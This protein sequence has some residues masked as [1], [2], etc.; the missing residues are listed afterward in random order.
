MPRR[1]LAVA[2]VWHMH[3]PWYRDDV[4]GQFVLP[5]VRRRA[6]KDYLHMLQVLD[7]HPDMR[8]TINMVPSL[9]A[10]LE[11]YDAGD[12]SDADRD[13]CL[14]SATDLTGAERAFLVAGAAHDD[15]GRRVGL[16]SPYIELVERLS[17]GDAAS[18]DVDD[19]RD[20]QLWSLL[21]W[22]D[23]DQIRADPALLALARRGRGFA[24]SDKHAVDHAQM[25]LLRAVIPAYREAVA[26]G[27]VEPM[28]SPFHHPILPL[29]IGATSA[30]VATPDIALPEPPLH[31]EPDAREHVRRGLDSFERVVGRHAAAMW[32]PECAVSP[33]AAALMR[34]CGVRFAIS[35]ELVLNRTLGHAARDTGELYR[36]HAD[37]SGLTMVFRDAVLS[38]LIGFSYQSMSADDAAADLLARLTGIANSQPEDGPERLVTIALDGE[39]FKDFYAENAT[40]F[41]DALYAGLVASAELQTTHIGAFLDGDSG[42]PATLPQLWT[43]SWVNADLR[44][45]IGDQ[46]HTR[47]WTLLAT[48]RDTLLRVD[49]P[50]VHPRAWDEL[51]I[52]ESSDWFWWFGEHHDSGFDA[53]WDELFRTHL[54]NAHTLAGVA[55]PAAVD[56]PLIASAALAHDCAPLRSIDPVRRG[57]V[58]W[59]CA[60]I[61]D[62]GAVYGAMRPPASSV[63]RI[64]YGA[65]GARLHIRFGE[66]TPRFDRVVIDAGPAGTLVVE[67]AAR[68]LSVATPVAGPL[69]FSITLE[70]AGRGTERVPLH[71]ALHVTNPVVDTDSRLRVVIVAAE[72]APL[73]TAGDLAGVVAAT[74]A[75]AAELGYEVIVITPHHREGSFGRSPGVRVALLTASAWGAPLEARVVQGALAGR[76]VPVLSIDAPVW[77]DRDAVYGAIDDGE[78]YLAFCALAY[79][80]IN[81]TGFAPDLVHGFEWQTAALLARVAALPSPPATI[82]S[83]G[84]GS[85]GYVVDAP[86]LASAGLAEAGG[87]AIDLIDLGRRVATVV[88]QRPRRQTLAQTYDAALSLHRSD[89]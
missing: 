49:A 10:Q 24:E 35:D 15:Y 21:A 63:T 76:E 67:R 59:Q 71:G 34:S 86:T 74:A 31:A 79:T 51:L 69:D 46:A 82:L 42:P 60:G 54:R 20:L 14:R 11:L 80:L 52:A 75:D 57:A 70:E 12:V 4:A 9:L 72:C 78:R 77:F 36:P 64:L 8:V 30:R 38:N 47:A 45:W 58:E 13:L 32:P 65:G 61:A 43:G 3:Q 48:T 73:V 7:R 17:G 41:L 84:D 16:L 18:A 68:S 6:A 2:L 39:N 53:S 1:P 66:G 56:Q 37:A 62:V 50:F 81:A 22:V 5:W 85:S 33:Q 83:V 44:T 19:I 27:R 23:P 55:V 28:T 88:E 25:R 29:L 89:R 87:G 26:W 40:P